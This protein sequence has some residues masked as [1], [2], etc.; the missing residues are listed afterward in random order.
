MPAQPVEMHARVERK[1]AIPELLKKPIGAAFSR[2]SG[3]DTNIADSSQFNS[4]NLKLRLPKDNLRVLAGREQI[5]AGH[6]PVGPRSTSCVTHF[7]TF[8]PKAVR[9]NLWRLLGGN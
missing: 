7:Q 4:W 2:S 8:R 3:G 1:R 6:C 5:T 9:A